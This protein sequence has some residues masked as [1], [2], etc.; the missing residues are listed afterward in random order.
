MGLKENPKTYFTLRVSASVGGLH[1]IPPR[2][3]SDCASGTPPSPSTRCLFL[4]TGSDL[5]MKEKV[6]LKKKRKEKLAHLL[7]G[8]LH[9]DQ[10]GDNE[11]NQNN[12]RRHS[13]DGAVGLR[14]LVE[15]S[16]GSLL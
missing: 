13:D 4:P 7:P 6:K 12:T 11:K 5:M 9:L 3:Q 10:D 1:T 15:E 2:F 16:F 8:L 14:Y